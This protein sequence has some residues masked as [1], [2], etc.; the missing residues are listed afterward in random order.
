MKKTIPVLRNEIITT[1]GRRSYV[2]LTFGIPIL[3]I[4]V[5]SVITLFQSRSPETEVDTSE[6]AGAD[7]I[8]LEGFIDQADLIQSLPPDIPGGMLTRF[9]T[10]SSAAEALESGE[11]N[12]YYIIPGDYIATG[13]L[14]YVS[15]EISPFGLA[16]QD[17]AI[18]WTLLYNLTGQDTELASFIWNP[19]NVEVTDLAAELS[20]AGSA[21]DGC[22]SAGYSCESNPLVRL[23]PM[24][25]LILF[26]IF[27]STSAGLLLRSVSKEKEN[28]TM[29]TLL[30]SLKPTELLSGKVIGLGLLAFLQMVLWVGTGFVILRIGG[31]TL[32]LPPGFELPVSILVWGTVLFLGGYAIYASLMAGLGALVPDIKAASQASFL[33]MLPLFI[34]YFIAVMPPV[35]EAPHGLLTTILSIFPFTAP[36]VMMMRLTVGGVP[37]WQLIL[38]VVLLIITVFAVVRAVS[39]MFHAQT[40][41][42]GQPFSPKRYLKALVG[43]D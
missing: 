32:N 4:L 15:P 21:G 33:V 1:L 20:P 38:T 39:G 34:G 9:E 37:T 12:A 16:G 28:R 13:R 31:N 11:I 22:T 27:I 14:Y 24:A 26:F 35:Q 7:E 19:M 36:V 30:L 43:Q 10:E 42:S 5:F 6:A 2:L 41:L 3:G 17:W 40:I 18:R 23:L 29:E 8:K 25:I